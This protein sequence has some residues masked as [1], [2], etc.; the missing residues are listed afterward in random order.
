MSL[1][2]R[3][4]CLEPLIFP[5]KIENRPGLSHI[6]YRIGTY[7]DFREALLRKLNLDPVL[8]P[9]THRKADDPGIALLEGASILGDILTFYQ[10]LYANEAYLKTAQWRESIADLVRLVGYHLSP[11]LGGKA[12]FAYEVK[13]DKPVVIPKGFHIKAQVEGAEKPV[14]FETTTEA[15]ACPYLSKFNLY[16]PTTI[17]NFPTK[18]SVFSMETSELEQAEI[19]IN[20]D[21]RLLLLDTTIGPTDNSQIA[22]VKEVEE[23][24]ERTVI[25]IEGVWNKGEG[26]KKIKAFKLGRSFRHFGHNAPPQVVDKS[27]P[28]ASLI[29]IE[30]NRKLHDKTEKALTEEWFIQPSIESTEI[31][32]D[33]EI[34]DFVIGSKVVIQGL[35]SSNGIEYNNV[36]NLITSL[37]K[38]TNNIWNLLLL[39]LFLQ[40]YFP[41]FNYVI[42]FW[43]WTDEE[44]KKALEAILSWNT[45]NKLKNVF[46]GT[47]VRDVKGARSGSMTWGAL[48]GSSTIIELTEDMDDWGIIVRP[49]KRI[50]DTLETDIRNLSIHETIGKRALTLTN[51]R[52]INSSADGKS[53]YFYGDAVTYT[54]LDKRHLAFVKKDGTSMQTFVETE[55]ASLSDPDRTKLRSLTLKT[56]LEDGFTLDD[57]PLEKPR[58]TVY[59]NL[60]AADQGKTEKEAVLGN[61]DSRQTFQNF[62]LPKA[63]LTYHNSPGETPPEVPELQ[64]YVND[65]LWKRVPSLFDRGSKEE[66]YIVREDAK[67]E[68]WVQFGDGKTGA[69]LPSGVRNVVAKYRTGTGAHGALKEETTV[70][71]G[72]KL[73]RLNKIRLPGIVTGGSD[74]ETGDNAR[75]AAPGKI[76]GLG[77]IVSLKDF[78]SEALAISGVSKVT[79]SWDLVDNVPSVV[80]TILME[81]GRDEEFGEVQKTLTRYNRC[82]GTQ[83]FSIDVRKGKH[84]YVYM[85]AVFGMDPTFREGPVKKAIKEALGVSGE[86]GNGIDGSRGLFGL[87]QRLF[88]QNEYATR[89]AGTIQNV[90]GVM[91]AE[92]KALGFLTGSSDKPSELNLPPEPKP[93][94][95]VV[96]CDNLHILSLYKDHLNLKGS[97]VMST[98]EC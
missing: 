2:C 16:R 95:S 98:E 61:G 96:S 76:Q 6:D 27:N 50:R 10:E 83:R 89:I 85:D 36:R 12:T 94:N 75:E 91:W 84:K 79:A 15:I 92:I 18:V 68:S 56:P 55:D 59:G 43:N 23:Q 19:E 4:D 66:I 90:E 88:G 47:I 31:P 29:D 78:E 5:K 34:D 44:I 9:W 11:G 63:P 93:L 52:Q 45:K 71:P 54:Q 32:L 7:S 70:Q 26:L 80:L 25:K 73:N 1:D 69:R 86:E 72:G 13:G 28:T 82:R 67:G 17:Q 62:K 74:P 77:R 22:V 49:K 81:T 21:D 30:F 39:M 33:S 65:R 35:K 46:G 37:F 60:V 42:D 3:N 58:V 51:T 53:L 87:H 20:K 24:F 48:T 14:D 41:Y 57:F 64:I 97:R 40:Y 38:A 8:A